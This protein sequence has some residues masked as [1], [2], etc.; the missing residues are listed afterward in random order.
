MSDEMNEAV[1]EEVPVKKK[2]AVR[3]KKVEGVED[4]EVSTRSEKLVGIDTS[5]RDV[6][7]Y[8]SEGCDLLFES[9]VGRFKELSDDVIK[10]LSSINRERYRLS[11]SYYLGE[12][13]RQE[14]PAT[15]GLEIVGR[16]ASATARLHIEN[17][18]PGMRYSWQTPHTMRA[19]AY[20]GYQV[21]KDPDLETFA[22]VGEGGTHK[23]SAL[24]ETELILM[25]TSQEN[26]DA[27]QRAIS[28]KSQQRNAS[29]MERA[30]QDIRS[31]GGR[32]YVPPK[33]PRAGGPQ[34]TPSGPQRTRE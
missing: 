8:D 31:S 33:G 15:E 29:Y 28:K 1:Q 34:F 11:R 7:Q 14:A 23:V 27:R 12:L 24:G 21:T 4:L 10:E 6:L 9:D 25:E 2:P 13:K 26:F 18:K 22:G 19:R 5:I 30:I 32:E 3:K 17:P 20:E 16:L